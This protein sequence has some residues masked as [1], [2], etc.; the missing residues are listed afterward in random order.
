MK[1]PLKWPL[2]DHMTGRVIK[3][4]GW[5]YVFVGAASLV[6]MLLL[7]LLPALLA[8]DALPARWIVGVTLATVLLLTLCGT[9]PFVWSVALSY[10]R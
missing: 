4:Q 1:G 2:G 5:A 7:L 3:L 9:V 6:L 10:R 8:D